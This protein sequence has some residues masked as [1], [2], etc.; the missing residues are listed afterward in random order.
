[1]QQARD[2]LGII[3]NHYEGIAESFQA[4]AQAIMKPIDVDLYYKLV[5]PDSR[6]PANEY[7]LLGV[8]KTRNRAKESFEEGRGNKLKAVAGTL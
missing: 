5:F 4:M 3:N 2:L 8:E 7:R 6:E 1:M